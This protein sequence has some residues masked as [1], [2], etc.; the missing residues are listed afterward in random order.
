VASTAGYAVH[1]AA[2]DPFAGE[3]AIE[4]VVLVVV[5]AL[6][7]YAVSVPGEFSPPLRGRQADGETTEI[8]FPDAV[9][10]GTTQGIAAAIGVRKRRVS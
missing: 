10:V 2:A 1:L 6:I 9:T 5:T 7:D 3:T 8:R 4:W